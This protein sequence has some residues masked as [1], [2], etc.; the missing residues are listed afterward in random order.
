MCTEGFAKNNFKHKEQQMATIKDR[1]REEIEYRQID[2]N[3]RCKKND[4]TPPLVGLTT[5]LA[6]NA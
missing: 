6:C 2:T 4:I 1:D 5:Y 3:A